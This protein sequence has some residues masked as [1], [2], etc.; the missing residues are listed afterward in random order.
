MMEAFRLADFPKGVVNLVS[1]RGSRAGA[2]LA[3]NPKVAMISFTVQP[4][5]A[6]L[7]RSRL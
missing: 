6:Y 5:S 3:L 7:F 4:Q 2:E 1:G